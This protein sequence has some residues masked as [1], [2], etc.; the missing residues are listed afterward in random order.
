[1]AK[2]K[3]VDEGDGFYTVKDVPIFQMHEDRGFPCDKSWMTAAIQS[4]EIYR[5][6]DY[7]PP[8]ILGHNKK[9][10]A[11]KEANGF[12]DN[13]ALKGKVLYADLVRVPR[14]L[15]EK[16]IRNAFPSRSVE[17][18]P[19]SKRILCMALLGGTT[20]HFS[21]PQMV[22]ENAPDA[23]DEL[24]LWF[25]SPKMAADDQ[26]NVLTAEQKASFAGLV[27][28]GIAAYVKET[29]TAAAAKTGE[30]PK[31]FLEEMED[32]KG[33]V[34][35]MLGYEDEEGKHHVGMVVPTAE[36]SPED[37]P[38]S[39]SIVVKPKI[40]EEDVGEESGDIDE[41]DNPEGTVD[42]EFEL[43]S[44]DKAVIYEINSLKREV[45]QLTTANQLLQTE[46][47]CK[48]LERY[49]MEKKKE[50]YPIGDI[51]ANVA[52]LIT[53]DD[54]GLKKFKA[55]LE[56]RPKIELG[57][58]TETTATFDAS[59]ADVAEDWDKNKET[60]EKY[61][62]DK[63]TAKYVRFLRVNKGVGEK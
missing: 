58:S 3:V 12:L 40:A 13:L 62:V 57:R 63:E 10:E 46:K 50:G 38:T 29:E 17:V 49:L 31:L 20:P 21:L 19:K 8:I 33:N 52:Y 53:L 42:E 51:E 5:A 2:F 6:K 11:E 60:Y 27:K 15:K 54:D 61:G 22:F 28:E 25:R 47:E 9:G 26:S 55:E 43:D 37:L 4:H 35:T 39:E 16:I 41:L 44:L 32:A 45:T 30:E 48:G 24:T 18:L 34:F 56:S 1:M 14:M 36:D 23:G 59:A 7:R